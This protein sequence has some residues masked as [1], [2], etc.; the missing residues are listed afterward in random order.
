MLL[1][2]LLVKHEN[3]GEFPSCTVLYCIPIHR[4]RYW[5]FMLPQTTQRSGIMDETLK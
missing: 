1:V 4:T 5:T 2:N 3:E